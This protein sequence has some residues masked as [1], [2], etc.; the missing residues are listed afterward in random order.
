MFMVCFHVLLGLSP[1][2]ESQSQTL[3]SQI[4]QWWWVWCSPAAQVLRE[5]WQ[6]TGSSRRLTP[7]ADPVACSV[8]MFQM[9]WRELSRFH[10]PPMTTP[11]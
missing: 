4:V 8:V 11:S 1:L 10:R 7:P 3:A 2:F 6:G 9:P 5:S